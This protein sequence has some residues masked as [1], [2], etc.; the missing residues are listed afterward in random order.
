M[1]KELWTEVSNIIQEMVT[2]IIP[3]K[4]KCKKATWL[5]EKVFFSEKRRNMKGMGERERYAQLN[6]AMF[7]RIARR[8]KKALHYS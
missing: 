5:S 7:Q 2:K 4:K 6:S 3:K 1:P 8:D